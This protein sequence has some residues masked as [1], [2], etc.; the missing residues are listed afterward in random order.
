[1]AK[2]KTGISG[3]IDSFQGDK[4]IWMIVFML[5]MISI[6]AISSST[7][8]LALQMKSTRSAIINEQILVAV[9][10][11]GIILFCYTCIRRIGFLRAISQLGFTVSF[12]MLLCL[13][14][15]INLPFLK[16]VN[17]NGATRALSIMGFQ[18]HVFEFVKV[19]MVM[20]LA[21]ACQALQEKDGFR[22]AAALS[23]LPHFE[24][25]GKKGWQLFFY[26]FLPIILVSV[27]IL[28]GSVSSFVTQ[29]ADCPV[30][31]CR[32]L[33]AEWELPAGK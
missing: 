31:L 24:F 25:L 15:H 16:A 3:F 1:M 26:I 27:L 28:M 10:G 6:L 22:M 29:H 13:A 7:P 2:K 12:L 19:F 4:I 32:G 9:L 11:L 33:P 14:I 5:I 30:L 8:L 17:I 18:L 23:Q 20:Y 21:W